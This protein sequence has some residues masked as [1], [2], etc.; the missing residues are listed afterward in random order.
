M[1]PGRARAASMADIEVWLDWQG[2][3]RPVGIVRRHAARGGE[4][5]TFSYHDEWISA[6]RG[7][8]IDPS[9]PLGAGTFS[10][11]PGHAMFG[12]MADTAP[13]SWGRTLMRRQERRNAEH[14]GRTVRTLQESD[15]LLGVSDH[16]RLGAL[17]FRHVGGDLFL[18][19]PE[20]ATPGLVALGRLRAAAERVL[21]GMDTDEDLLAI[22][23]PG[24]SL[25]GARPK[26]SVV[27]QFGTLSV[28][29]LPKDTDEYSVERWE[30][31]ALDLAQ[32]AGIR[33]AG[34]DI[35]D[36]RGRPIFV[37]RRFDRTAGQRLPFMSAMAMTGR[38]D[39]ERGSYLE[40]VDVLTTHGAN[41]AADRSELFRRVAFSLLV[42]N[43]DDHLRNH[44]FLRLDHR[45]WSLSPAY[46]INPTPQDI[47]P[48]ILTTNIDLDD[49]TCSIELLRSVAEEFCLKLADADLLIRD[50]ARV[51]CAWRDAARRRG[52]PEPE[53]R[54]MASAFEHADLD[55]AL[56][57]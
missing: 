54:R 42:S 43:T 50:V 20:R 44:G 7:Y 26:A 9:L 31:I 14:D 32:T 2:H 34:H 48:R 5:V 15:F 30:A 38:R 17:R 45:G 47:G 49:G 3:C 24:S 1:S 37:S 21:Q 28:A 23:A 16:A 6:P 51:T 4:R 13:D 8:A 11:P 36:D 57:L 33:A 56:A 10:P 12:A 29:K 52:A 41:A 25:G 19:P 39:G 53:I 55:T 40:L 18:A 22:L 35:H 46:D 27:D